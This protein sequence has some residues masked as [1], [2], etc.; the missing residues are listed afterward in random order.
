MC[1]ISM[2]ELT[3]ENLKKS[4]SKKIN[5]IKKSLYTYMDIIRDLKIFICVI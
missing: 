5:I 4:L 2:S 1:E 3:Y